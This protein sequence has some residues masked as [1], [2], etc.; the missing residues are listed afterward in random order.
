MRKRMIVLLCGALAWSVAGAADPLDLR[1]ARPR[2][3]RVAFEVSPT[4]RPDAQNVVYS[5]PVAAWLEPGAA[6]GQVRVRVPGRAME[7][8]LAKFDPVP[9]SFGDYLWTF[10]AASGE[11]LSAGFEGRLRQ[12]VDFGLFRS[13]VETRIVVQVGTR[14]AIGFRAPY[15]QLGQV[16][17]GVCEPGSPGCTRVAPAPLD[18]HTGH[19]NAVGTIRASAIGGLGALTFS[20]L[21]EAVFSE[22]SDLPAVSLAAE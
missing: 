12:N 13:A 22:L 3:V 5:E 15:T 4:E 9:G 20:P 21:G 17:V 14:A 2:Q 8:L 11:V 16:V 1:D 7:R 10:D 18:P 6:P 19:V